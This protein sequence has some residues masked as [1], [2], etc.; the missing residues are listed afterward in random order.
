MWANQSLIISTCNLHCSHYWGSQ[1]TSCSE[2]WILLPTFEKTSM[3]KAVCH[4]YCLKSP[5]ESML[6][7]VYNSSLLC[8]RTMSLNCIDVFMEWLHC[9]WRTAA[10]QWPMLLAVSIC[11]LPVVGSYHSLTQ[12]YCLNSFGHHSFAVAVPSIWNIATWRYS[13]PSTEYHHVLASADDI[14]FLWNID[15]MH[16]AHW[17]YFENML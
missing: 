1:R 2:W 13:L 11:G 3:F 6:L 4:G 12:C 7:T 15:K 5:T 8:I 17:R 10:H 9:T 16:L 14:L